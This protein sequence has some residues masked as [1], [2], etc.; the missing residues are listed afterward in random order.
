MHV[1]AWIMAIGAMIA[2]VASWS[3]TNTP[4]R[5]Y[6]Y[7]GLAILVIG[8]VGVGVS[9]IQVWSRWLNARRTPKAVDRTTS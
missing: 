7:G 6:G 4:M 8:L 2:V 9:W 1:F 3:S 5:P